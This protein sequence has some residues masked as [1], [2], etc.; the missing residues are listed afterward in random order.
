M[1]EDKR[2]NAALEDLHESAFEALMLHTGCDKD[3]WFEVMFEEY[4]IDIIDAY[5]TD[6]EEVMAAVSN[7]WNEPYH[8]DRSGQTHTFAEWAGIFKD[9]QAVEEYCKSNTIVLPD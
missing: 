5:G 3:T 6:E 2:H 4:G 8:D 7:L 1:N 9:E